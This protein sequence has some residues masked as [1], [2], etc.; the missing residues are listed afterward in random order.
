MKNAVDARGGG[1]FGKS[2]H[3]VALQN[4][5]PD[6]DGGDT[7]SRSELAML[8]MECQQCARSSLPASP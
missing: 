4:E 8:A 3:G 1:G 6:C 7:A 2:P 5:F